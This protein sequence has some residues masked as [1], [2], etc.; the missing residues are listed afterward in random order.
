[1]SE[2]GKIRKKEREE[3]QEKQA[4]KV[5]NWIFGVLIFLA[6]CFMIYSVWLV[7]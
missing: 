2:K 7:S 1:M 5:I 3:K 4:R 6:V